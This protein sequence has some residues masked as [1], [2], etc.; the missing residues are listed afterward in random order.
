MSR[1]GWLVCGLVVALGGCAA[2]GPVT[3]ER[4]GA[5]LITCEHWGFGWL[6]LPLAAALHS[7]CKSQARAEGYEETEQSKQR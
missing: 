6:G 7:Q 2:F 1:H 3:F 4:P 5:P